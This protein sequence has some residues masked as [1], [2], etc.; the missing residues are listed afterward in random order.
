MATSQSSVYQLKAVVGKLPTLLC[1]Q[2]DLLYSDSKNKRTAILRRLSKAQHVIKL[3]FRK[4]L[5]FFFKQVSSLDQ[6][7][8]HNELLR[9]YFGKTE[10]RIAYIVQICLYTITTVSPSLSIIYRTNLQVSYQ[11]LVADLLSRNKFQ[12]LLILHIQ[13]IILNIC[14]PRRLNSFVK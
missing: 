5:S 4:Q 11:D 6:F 14:T 3:F 2:N 7:S 8:I 10:P 12:I 1:S 13:V 9:L